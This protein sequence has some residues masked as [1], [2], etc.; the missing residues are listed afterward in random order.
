[1]TVVEGMFIVFTAGFVLD[2]FATSQEHGWTGE[3]RAAETSELMDSIRC[4]RVST[5]G[6]ESFADV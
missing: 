4:Q 3:Y 5:R 1:M 2:E 6:E